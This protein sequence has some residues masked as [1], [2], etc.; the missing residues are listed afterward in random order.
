MIRALY[1]AA[2]GMMV[3]ARRL[4]LVS[5]NLFH[6]QTPGFKA[7]RELRASRGPTTPELPSDVQVRL[8]GEFVDASPGQFRPTGRDLDLAI[9]GNGF[10][11]VETP[12]GTAY[13][14][15]GRFRK[16]PDGVV[17]DGNGNA[18]LGQGGPIRFPA[19]AGPD[20]QVEVDGNGALRVGGIEVDL[21][22]LADFPGYRG[23]RQAGGSYFFAAGGANSQPSKGRVL[24]RTLEDANVSGVA[25]MSRTIETLRAFESYQKM[26]QSVMDETT[27]EAVRRIGRVA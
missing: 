4:D 6:V 18:L 8:E 9:E 19:D 21:I 1:T 14:R 2:S 12:G 13:T 24:Q 16:G 25:E 5:K 22:A 20:A 15:D 27:G 17:R 3:E 26:I 10:F 11:T 23:L 7:T